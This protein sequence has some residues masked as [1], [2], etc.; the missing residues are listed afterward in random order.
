ME[1]SN[2]E[3]IKQLVQR[4]DGVSLVV[5]EAVTDELK[6]KRLAAV[7]L[8]GQKLYLDVNIA[9]LK[10]QVLSPPAKAFVDTLIGL[11]SDDLHPMGIGLMM[12]KML[13][14]RKE[15]Q[16]KISRGKESRQ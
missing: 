1:T 5:R 9:C 3:F 15:E 16:R 2:T 14:Q 10:D 8:K 13:A 11:K 4:G 12:A 6:G 7:L